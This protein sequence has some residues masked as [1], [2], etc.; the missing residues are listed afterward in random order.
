VYLANLNLIVSVMD[1]R[2]DSK[3]WER[4]RQGFFTLF[5]RLAGLHLSHRF[6]PGIDTIPAVWADSR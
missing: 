5:E 1:L 4:F 2:R 3:H 6:V